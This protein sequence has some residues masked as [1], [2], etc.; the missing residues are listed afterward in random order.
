MLQKRLASQILKCSPK[1]VK[2]DTDKLAEIKEAITR[3]DVRSMIESGAITKMQKRGVSKGRHRK[4][5]IQK[6]KGRRKGAGTK[7]GK[8]TAKIGK[9]EVWMNRIRLQRSFLNELKDKKIVDVQTYR[10]LYRKAKGGFFRNKR[11]I[12]LYIEEHKLN[13]RT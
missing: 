6:R 11:H 8:K 2:I 7:K 9:K 1:R 10:D 3:E 5:L 12:S 4:F 13:T